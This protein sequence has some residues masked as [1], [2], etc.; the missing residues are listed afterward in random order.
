MKKTRAIVIALPVV[1]AAIMLGTG[2]AMA[3][4]DYYPATDWKLQD[5]DATTY[6]CTQDP[7]TVRTPAAESA[8]VNATTVKLVGDETEKHGTS[9]ETTNLD[10]SG[11]TVTVD[12]KLNGANPV[13]GA[14]RMFVYDHAN[15]DTDC[16]APETTPGTRNG[17][18]VVAADSAVTGTLTLPVPFTGKIGTFG[19][20]YDSSNTTFAGSVEFSNVKVDGK[21]VLFLKRVIAGAPTVEPYECADEEYVAD[22]TIPDTEGV[23]YKIGNEVLASGDYPF[24]PG[25]Y[26][27]TAHA[28]AGYELTGTTEWTLNIEAINECSSAP[29]AGGDDGNAAPLPIT[30]VNTKVLGLAGAGAVLAGVLALLLGRRKRAVVE[31]TTE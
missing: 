18:A 12:Y 31:P 20:V 8:I 30:G 9:L 11:S 7:A 25:E 5:T 15:A 1:A 24:E 27:V 21:T 6:D 2:P 26:K 13:S 29:P 4:T 10:L 19:L 22:V 16:E 28:E 23:V 17:E 3:D 14:I